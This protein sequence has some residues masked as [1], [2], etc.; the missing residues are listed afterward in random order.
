MNNDSDDERLEKKDKLTAY[1]FE[2]LTDYINNHDIPRSLVMWSVF[3][4]C[5]FMFVISSSYS[6]KEQ[7]EEIDSFCEHLKRYAMNNPFKD[8]L[9]N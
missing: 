8:R 7:C 6:I 2:K 9:I 1:L 5:I 4:L 3:D